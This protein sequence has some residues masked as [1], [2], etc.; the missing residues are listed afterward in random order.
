MKRRASDLI[1]LLILVLGLL[2]ST[3]YADAAFTAD[4][5]TLYFNN[6]RPET[7]VDRNTK[8]L[9]AF[10][11]IRYSGTGLLEGD[12]K[13]DGRVISHISLHVTGNNRIVTIRTPEGSPLPTFAEGTHIVQFIMT[14]PRAALSFPSIV[15]F[16]T[17]K[18]APFEIKLILPTDN[19]S[20]PSAKAAFSWEAMKK[21]AQYL[22]GFYT[23]P[24]G[25]PVFSAITK[26]ASYTI[27]EAVLKTVFSP[28]KK[29]YRKVSG[30]EQGSS[31]TGE[32][33]LQKFV[34]Q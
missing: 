19:S 7:T 1:A 31:V 13:V 10:A 25:K 27:P 12:W 24:A 6:N 16:V 30:Y 2:A 26:D 14:S 20:L 17:P 15:Y 33:A 18:E 8:N 23:G 3:P 22:I 21:P 29:Y 32:S 4:R 28:G 11:D 5:I 34:L 9:Q